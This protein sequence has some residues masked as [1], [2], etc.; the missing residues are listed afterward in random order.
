[1]IADSSAVLRMQTVTVSATK[2]N[3]VHQAAA[4][5][6]GVHE[7]E[8][9]LIPGDETGAAQEED[10][11]IANDKEKQLATDAEIK[12]TEEE[13]KKTETGGQQESPEPEKPEEEPK[14]QGQDEKEQGEAD[15][16]AKETETSAQDLQR[17]TESKNDKE[18]ESE[19]E[20]LSAEQQRLSTLEDGAT[21]EE[22]VMEKTVETG[23]AKHQ[24][25]PCA[26]VPKHQNF[27]DPPERRF[28]L[29]A[30]ALRL[31]PPRGA[32]TDGR[33]WGRHSKVN[34]PESRKVLHLRVFHKRTNAA[35]ESQPRS[36]VGLLLAFLLSQSCASCCTVAAIV[37]FLSNPDP[38]ALLIL[39]T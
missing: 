26:V 39:F 6:S 1:M 23:I 13:E 17:S 34:P 15:Q 21:Y 18:K 38:R 28:P 31:L 22:A 20:S 4:E 29:T 30:R 36:S 11:A 33:K 8:D 32:K 9:K 27:P 14:Q 37:I 3:A 7:Q 5:E 35:L 10:G 24:E 16:H 12:D 19:A 2:T 25:Q